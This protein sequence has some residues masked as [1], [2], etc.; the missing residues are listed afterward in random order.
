MKFRTPLMIACVI[1]VG[2]AGM[3]IADITQQKQTAS[4]ALLIAVSDADI[5]NL[6]YMR[7]EEKLARDV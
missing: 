1:L 5:E 6:L 2:L 4:R 7:Q 3:T